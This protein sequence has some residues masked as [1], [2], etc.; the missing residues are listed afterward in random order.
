MG[1]GFIRWNSMIFNK[2]SFV[3]L[4]TGTLTPLM[5]NISLKIW[6][7]VSSKTSDFIAW[8]VW[9]FDAHN[10]LRADCGISVIYIIHGHWFIKIHKKY[11]L[12]TKI[13][14]MSRPAVADE[15]TSWHDPGSLAFVSTPWR[16][17]L[18]TF[19]FYFESERRL[20]SLE[21]KHKHNHCL[22]SCHIDTA[23]NTPLGF[24][25][26]KLSAFISELVEAGRMLSGRWVAL[27]YCGVT[28]EL[29][30]LLSPH[31]ATAPLPS[32]TPATPAAPPHSQWAQAGTE[33][34]Q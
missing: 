23:D 30:P 9:V 8:I 19:Q 28:S 15:V 21:D 31:S 5:T 27:D 7:S 14:Y 24:V 34:R 22:H 10:L 4:V 12:Y 11:I 3:E 2:I 29:C 26:D 25:S 18:V 32:P 1:T 17:T 33:G 6:S 20:N 13:Q 16:E